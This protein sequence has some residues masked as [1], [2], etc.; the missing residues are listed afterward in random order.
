[1][2]LAHAIHV[3]LFLVRFQIVPGLLLQGRIARIFLQAV[4]HVNIYALFACTVLG[5]LAQLISLLVLP[6]NGLS[7]MPMYRRKICVNNCLC[8]R[9][10]SHDVPNNTFRRAD[11]QKLAVFGVVPLVRCRN[12]LLG[13]N[14]ALLLNLGLQIAHLTHPHIVCLERFAVAHDLSGF[15]RGNL[16]RT[17]HLTTS[18]VL[19]RI[20]QIGFSQLHFLSQPHKS[21]TFNLAIIR[22]LNNAV[23]NAA[24]HHRRIYRARCRAVRRLSGSLRLMLG[25]YPFS[26][27]PRFLFCHPR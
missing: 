23:Y 13:C 7:L 9:R 22:D 27:L 18:S 25:M 2:H 5:D 3:D 12:Q 15:F 4:V 26:P 8:F 6:T 20:H 14:P 11:V 19:T 10:I 21:Q 1:M 17:G 24:L 16:A